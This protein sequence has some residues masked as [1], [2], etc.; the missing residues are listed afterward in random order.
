MATNFDLAP[1]PVSFD[2]KTAVPI[3]ISTIDAHLIFD[4]ATSTASGDATLTF[5][6]GSAA[7]RPM[8]DV[9]QTITGVWLDGAAL[10]VGQVLTRDLGGGPGAE[11]RV[12]DVPLAAGSSHTLRITYTLG[13]PASPPGGS[14]A[15][16]L[17]WS[18][19]PRLVFNVGFTDLAAARYLEAWVPANL[20]WDQYAVNLELQVTGTAVAHRVI[21]NGTITAVATNHWR[22]AFPDRVTA[23]STLVEVRASDTLSSSS[24]TVT[25]PVSGRVI[26]I[27][28]FKLASNTT[29][30][31]ATVLA[32]LSVWLVENESHAGPYL[33]ANRFVAFM[34]QGGMEYEGGCTSGQGSLRHE[35]FH[36]WW[37]R[38][39]KPASQADG[40]WD[41]AWNV[42]HDNGG[43][44]TQPFDFT[45]SPVTLSTRNAY[46]RVTPS[47]AYSSGERFFEGVAALTSPA[48]LTGWMGEFYRQHLDRPVSTL[49]LEAHLVARAGQPDLVDAFHRWI[50]GFPDPSPAPD[51]WLRDDPAHTGTEAWAGRFWDSPDLWIRHADDAGT[52]HQAP[53]AGRDNWFH[54]RIRNRGTGAAR[55]F[56]VTFQVKQFAGVQFT[57]PA[58]FLPAIAAAGGFDLAPG[59]DRIVRAR[60]PAA[61]VPPAGTHAC[62]LA[63]VLARSDRPVGGAHVWEHGNLA[64]KNLTVV[65]VKRG[66]SLV[67]PF[68]LRGLKLNDERVVELVRPPS[69]A[70]I[71]AALVP[72]ASAPPPAPPDVGDALE[73]GQFASRRRRD[74]VL[75]ADDGVA[76]ADGGFEIDKAKLFPPGPVARLPVRLPMG[77]AMLGLLLRVGADTPPGSHGTI[78]LILRDAAG[79]ASGGLAIELMVAD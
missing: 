73:H 12:L 72:R 28:A 77:P 18:A 51:L 46:S 68:V 63:A 14:Y 64:Q 45:E 22:V 61:L 67:L 3:D 79:K 29:L 27:E 57:W 40:W 59:A 2:G 49:D 62:W 37:G 56:V 23:L 78:D 32:N 31:L 55:H 21:T 13:L 25:L 34:I 71:G 8:F 1:P 50:Y 5:V 33:H 54:A 52:V 39:V 7:G 58:D 10:A 60:W 19:G 17:A 16:G 38:G 48:S 41:E 43:T 26:T 6:V 15:P 66:K 76:L 30:S 20:I 36:S 69:L 74:E 9:R 11:L 75:D 24:T 42:Y 4:G 47:A 53:I 44:G 65:K 70:H 35:T